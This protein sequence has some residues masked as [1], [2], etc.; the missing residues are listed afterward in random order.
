MMFSKLFVAA[1]GAFALSNAAVLSLFGD[2]NCATQVGSRNVFD[3][4][5]A[6]NGVPG[7]QSFMITFPGGQDQT[8]IT[9]S[10]NICLNTQ[11]NSVSA[12]D[13][14]VCFSALDK[15]GGS[16]AIQSFSSEFTLT[17]ILGA[18]AS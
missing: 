15:N 2:P 13:V 6:S 11:T 7:F 14:G 17:N 8:I 3:S 10:Q 4:T 1:V 16:N 12:T 5:C 9:F 18:L